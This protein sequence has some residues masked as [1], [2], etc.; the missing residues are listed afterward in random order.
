MKLATFNQALRA[1]KTVEQLNQLLTSF[2][3]EIG[4]TTFSFTYYSRHA[5]AKNKLK[6]DFCS[7]NYVTWHQHYLSEHYEEVDV[8][9][10][11]VYQGTLPVYWETATQLRMAK[12]ERERKMREDSVAFGVEKGVS[13]PIH[14]PHGDF[15]NMMVA[16]MKGESGLNEVS[17]LQF[18]LLAASHSYYAALQ[19]RL[20]RLQAK[21]LKYDLTEREIACLIWVAQQFSVAD[22]AKKCHITERTV[23]Y[24]IQKVNKKLGVR[25]KHQAVRRALEEG[26]I[27]V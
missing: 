27:Q 12:S 13:I 24:H 16:Q 26:L 19:N 25:N 5:N 6:Y 22:I 14:G 21:K 17:D 11:E 8:T 23:N 4:I 1:A 15:A 9:L 18:V 7:K 2:F 10:T 3:N 20:P